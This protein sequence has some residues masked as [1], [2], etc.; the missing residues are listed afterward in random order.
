M[1]RKRYILCLENG[2]ILCRRLGRVD[3]RAE[4][5]EAS[6]LERLGYRS[7]I[8]ALAAVSVSGVYG[9]CIEI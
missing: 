8:N 7:L 1:G 4:P 9:R 6:I 3:I 5:R 2:V